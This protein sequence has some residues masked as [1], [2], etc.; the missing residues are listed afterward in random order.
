MPYRFLEDVTVA[1]VAFEAEGN[2]LQEL[3][4]SAAIALTNTMIN[5]PT[6]LKS[7]SVRTVRLSTENIEKLLYEFLQELIFLKDTELLLFKDITVDLHK[8]NSSYKLE[9]EL[10]G[11]KLSSQRH[12]LL[13]DV[14]AVTLHKFSVKHEGD[15]WRCM[16]VLDV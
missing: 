5:D 15:V 2:T 6:K 10:K 3:F 16:V 8:A 9:A 13:V 12:E 11:E 7:E 14:K 4:K 1:D